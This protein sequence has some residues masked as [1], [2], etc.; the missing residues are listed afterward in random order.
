MGPEW[1]GTRPPPDRPCLQGKKMAA[2]AAAAAAR[3]SGGSAI[4]GAAGA[5]YFAPAVAGATCGAAGA[6][7][8]KSNGE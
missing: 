2:A 6:A 4:Y 5:M 7:K 8:T 1:V 3:R